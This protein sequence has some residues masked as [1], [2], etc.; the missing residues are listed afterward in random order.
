MAWRFDWGWVPI[1][2]LMVAGA[3]AMEIL[4]L[5]VIFEREGEE[6]TEKEG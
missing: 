4:R 3:G 2:V 1:R 6:K 5:L